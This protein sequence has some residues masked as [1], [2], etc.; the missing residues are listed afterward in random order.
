MAYAQPLLAATAMTAGIAFAYRY[1]LRAGFLNDDYGLLA[2][3]AQYGALES[4]WI[5]WGDHFIPVYRLIVSVQW[6]LFGLEPAGYHACSIALH[7]VNALLLLW[8]G[9]RL[10]DDLP[11]ALTGALLFAFFPLSAGTVMAMNYASSLSATTAILV[12]LHALVDRGPP[13]RLATH[14]ARLAA[15]AGATAAALGCHGAA[16]VVVAAPLAVAWVTRSRDG[17]LRALGAV[18]AGVAA[19]LALRTGLARPELQ[20]LGPIADSL[21][22]LGLPLDASGAMVARLT[23]PATLTGLAGRLWYAVA[24]AAWCIPA[25]AVL[26]AIWLAGLVRHRL[27]WAGAALAAATWVGLF[28]RRFA[29][30]PMAVMADRYWYVP[31]LGIGLLTAAGAGISRSRAWRALTAAA[32]AV[33]ISAAAGTIHRAGMKYVK[34][35]KRA[36]AVIATYRDGMARYFARVPPGARL[37]FENRFFSR[38]KVGPFVHLEQI[39][40]LYFPERPEIR[41]VWPGEGPALLVWDPVVRVRGAPPPPPAPPP[42]PGAQPDAG[43]G[44]R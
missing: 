21:A 28:V 43:A 14:P 29:L 11:A 37:T 44:G 7:A 20:H 1:A 39:Y 17:I 6:T 8:L 34:R 35:S 5:P 36:D 40:R 27:A 10:L 38:S 15:A 32:L 42:S 31:A 26:V 19:F 13:P 25:G 2:Q 41:F 33:A 3:R 24:P 23:V 9:V 4:L 30:F 16:W 18:A 12:T 22:T